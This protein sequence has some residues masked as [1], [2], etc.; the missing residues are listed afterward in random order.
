MYK[1]STVSEI[2][3]LIAKAAFMQAILWPT[4]Q[5][6]N[7]DVQKNGPENAFSKYSLLPF[8]FLLN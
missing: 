4:N 2:P 8:F 5:S 3:A 6:Q 7:I 1:W